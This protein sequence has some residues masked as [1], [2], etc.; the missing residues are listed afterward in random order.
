MFWSTFRYCQLPDIIIDLRHT[1]TQSF[2][3]NC[4]SFSCI[5]YDFDLHVRKLLIHKRSCL[6]ELYLHGALINQHAVELNE[7]VVGAACFAEDDSCNAAAHTIGPVGEHGSVDR[8]N[9][10]AE[11]LL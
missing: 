7:S 1:V 11:I 5:E 10:F 2:C 4:C 8:A 6:S 9:R 3:R